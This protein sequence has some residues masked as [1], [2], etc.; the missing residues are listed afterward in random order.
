MRLISSGPNTGFAEINLPSLQPGSSIM[1][2]KINPVMP[3]LAAM[4]GFP[5][6]RQ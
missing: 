4:V 3:E 6:R 1:P 5:G 2:G